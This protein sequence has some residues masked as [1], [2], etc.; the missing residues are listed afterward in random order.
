M[1]KNLIDIPSAASLALPAFPEIVRDVIAR[2]IIEANIIKNKKTSIDS[3]YVTQDVL[4]ELK[5][6]GYEIS[7]FAGTTIIT[8]D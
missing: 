7:E 5:E 2:K 1:Y 3:R 6:K 8:W 4:T